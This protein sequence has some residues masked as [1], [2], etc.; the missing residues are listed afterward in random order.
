MDSLNLALVPQWR[1]SGYH[2]R[3]LHALLS[4]RASEMFRLRIETV[5]EDASAALAGKASF[6]KR[7]A[8]EPGSWLFALSGSSSDPAG[9]RV[10][11]KER[12]TRKLLFA[13]ACL[14]ENATGQGNASGV[15]SPLF[16][17]PQPLQLVDPGIIAA[18][19]TNLATTANEIQFVLW[20]AEKVVE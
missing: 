15:T 10:Q 16:I 2:A 7:I 18:Q 20:I 4:V 3:A 12:T 11:I 5:P 1:G 14:F 9:Y 6:E 19:V 8:L 13:T 17:L